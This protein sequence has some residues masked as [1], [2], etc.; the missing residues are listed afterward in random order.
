LETLF[1]VV[2]AKPHQGT[3][4]GTIKFSPIFLF[5]KRK[6]RKTPHPHNLEDLFLFI[7][8]KGSKIQEQTLILWGA[9]PKYLQ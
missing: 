1:L 4:L 2:Q 7:Y 8:F 9:H 3:H 6:K 5:Q